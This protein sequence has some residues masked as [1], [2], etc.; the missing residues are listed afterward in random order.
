M[1]L[2]RNSYA[3]MDYDKAIEHYNRI[4]TLYPDYPSGY[5]FRAE[6]YLAKKEYLKAIDDICKA[7]EINH[8]DKAQYLL[9]Q[10]PKE[11]LLLVVT[12]L[13][14]LSVKYPHI[15]NYEYY[16]AQVYAYQRMFVESN[17]ALDRKSVV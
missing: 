8:D 9:S 14:Y 6:A 3:R 17:E 2:G 7:L 12:K 16:M 5:S 1:G 10:F 15:I 11:Q 13:K 4:I